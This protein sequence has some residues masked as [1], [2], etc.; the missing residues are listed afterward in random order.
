MLY[1]NYL[2]QKLLWYSVYRRRDSSHS[3]K[4]KDS[5]RAWTKDEKEAM[6][7]NLDAVVA[8]GSQGN[9]G[10]FKSGSYKHI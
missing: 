8:N 4:Q 5:R 1:F 3:R 7:N 10:T 6:L 9:N 2:F